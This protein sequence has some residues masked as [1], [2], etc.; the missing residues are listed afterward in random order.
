M[1]I[2]FLAMSGI[3]AHNPEL[4]ELGLTLPGFVERSKQVAA[5]PS[6]GLL[7]LAAVTPAG[8]ELAYF[9]APR[10]G[11]EPDELLACD[12]VAI[13]T[14]SAQIFEAYA[15]ADRLRAAGVT[16]AIGGLH[17]TVLPEEAREHADHVVVGEGENVWPAVVRA[18]ERREPGR[19]WRAREC[20]PVDVAALPV[21][22]YDLLG[23]RPYNR[24]TV[25]TS[26]GCPWRCEFCASSVML[27]E[28]YRR[29]PVEHVVRDVKAILEHRPDAFL[30]LADDDTFVDKAWS[31][32]LVRAL[33]S[34]GVKWFTETDV[35]VADDPELVDL[36][37]ESGCR[38]LLIGLESPD[39]SALGGLELRSDFKAR[40]APDYERAIDALQSRGVTVDGCFVLG[41]DRH[42]PEIFD[43]VL[44]FARRTALYEVQ[45]TYLTPFPGTP[46][47]ARLER[48]GRL[49]FP[50]RWDLCTLFDVTFT[51]QRMTP[52]ELRRGFHALTRELYSRDALHA[53]RSAFFERLHARRA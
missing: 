15:V 1:K 52:E 11:D 31:K 39:V 51:P 32:E 16:V 20:G 28:K 17:A 50:G 25:Q 45:I 13:S 6:L 23:D 29:R 46:L 7:Y 14:F 43:E 24:F 53:R 10:A 2:G 47:Y 27:G 12:L 38:Q 37:A 19:I 18:V 4:L 42:G 9:E 21:P 34:L 41:L 36:L 22:R 3:R 44:A 33:G 5:L 49:L 40:R 8:H 48:E 26:R 30:E 35:S